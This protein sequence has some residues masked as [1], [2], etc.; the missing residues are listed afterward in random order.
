MTKTLVD[1]IE[2]CSE[3]SVPG[4]PLDSVDGEPSLEQPATGKP[5]TYGQ[6]VDVSQFL[7]ADYEKHPD[8][9]RLQ[10]L[11]GHFKYSLESLLQGS[12][13]YAD[14]TKPKTVTVSSTSTT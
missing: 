2:C 1:A 12:R 13:V 14:A 7:K 9:E 6:V 10:T 11:D 5:I 4:W 3:R 8:D